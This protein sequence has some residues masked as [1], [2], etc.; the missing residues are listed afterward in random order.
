MEVLADKNSEFLKNDFLF[1]QLSVSPIHRFSVSY[2]LYHDYGYT[3]NLKLRIEQH[4]NGEVQSTK[5]RRPLELIYY[6]ACLSYSTGQ[7]Q[8]A[9][10]LGAE[11]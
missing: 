9:D 6:E 8:T 4:N 2:L 7:E 1:L 3:K 11:E 5:Y 10:K